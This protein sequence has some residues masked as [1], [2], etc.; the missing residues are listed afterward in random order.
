MTR[1]LI[2][3]GAFAAGLLLGLCAGNPYAAAGKAAEGGWL[4]APIAVVEGG[5]A[6]AIGGNGLGP[7]SP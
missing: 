4:A 1:R 3:S 5:A 7:S 6:V 2:A